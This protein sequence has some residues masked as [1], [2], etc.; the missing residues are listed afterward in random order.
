MIVYSQSASQSKR[1]LIDLIV[2]LSHNT[3]HK[4]ESMLDIAVKRLLLMKL[5][6]LACP[7]SGHRVAEHARITSV[8]HGVVSVSLIP[9]WPWWEMF[10]LLFSRSKKRRLIDCPEELLLGL[11]R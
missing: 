10:G 11:L 3:L 6:G 7:S 1:S 8:E 5:S 4:S 2:F 9:A